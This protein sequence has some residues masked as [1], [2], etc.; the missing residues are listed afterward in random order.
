MKAAAGLLCVLAVI[1]SSALADML[2]GQTS[3][4]QLNIKRHDD[5]MYGT[6]RSTMGDGINFVSEKEALSVTTLVGKPILKVSKPVVSDES[7]EI[8]NINILGQSV[9]KFGLDYYILPHDTNLDVELLRN[10]KELLAILQGTG[11]HQAEVSKLIMDLASQREAILMEYAAVAAGRE[12]GISG[13]EEP[14]ILPFY[15]TALTLSK[16]RNKPSFES[17]SYSPVTIEGSGYFDCD[18]T[19]CPPCQEDECKGM[20]GSNCDCWKWVCGDCCYH[21]GC[22]EHDVCCGGPLSYFDP[23]CVDVIIIYASFQFKCDGPYPA[24]CNY[25]TI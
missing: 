3:K 12:F 7:M 16:L 4:G 6:F 24:N 17:T 2:E 22:A 5:V 1:A 13:K 11:N 23:A 10:P 20:C 18:L 15:M 9:V 19:T 14:A 25:H 8:R 21:Q